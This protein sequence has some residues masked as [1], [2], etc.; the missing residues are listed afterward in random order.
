MEPEKQKPVL[1]DEQKDA[2]YC[3]DNAVI[4]AG[5]GSGKTLV[6]ASRFAWLVTQK[7]YR[8][9]EILT[10]TFT[11]KAAAQMYR[12]IYLQLAE[13]ARDDSGEKGAL[14]KQ[15]LDEFTQARIQ[16]LDSYCAAIV[17]QAAN[18]YGIKPDF[19]INEDRCRQLATDI[20]LPFL[21]SR[22][23]HH[24]IVRFYPHKSPLSIAKDIFAQALINYSH[25]DSP[26]RFREGMKDQS[27][28]ICREWKRQSE[29]ICAKLHEL[30]DVYCG[31]ENFHKDLAPLL[32]PFTAGSITFPTE[33]LADWFNKLVAIPHDSAIEWA[34]SHPQYRK[35]VNAFT[36]FSSICGL[37]LRKGSP[38]NNPAKDIIK[39][40]QALYREFSSVAVFCLQAGLIH[41]VLALLSELQQNYLDRKRS[42]GVLTYNDVAHLAKTILREQPDIRRS[43]KESFK[44]IMIDEFQDNNELQKDLLFLLAEKP[45][46]VNDS[47]PSAQD[48]T[49]GKLFFVGDEKQSIYRFRGAD[50]SVFRSLQKELG[51]RELPLK[52]NYRSA[53]ALIGAFNAIFG[54]SAFDPEGKTALA[55]NPAVFAPATDTTS[56]PPYEASFTPLRAD[57]KNMGKLT[58]CILDKQ[59]SGENEFDEENLL[60]VENEARFVAERI[61]ALL[62]EKDETGSL[63][64]QPGDIAILFRSRT[65]Q[66]IFEK[67]LML[68]NIPY[69]SE[70]LN[71][72]FFGGPVNDMMSVLRLAVYPKDKAAYAQIL[73]SPFAGLSLPGLMLCLSLDQAADGEPSADNVPFGDEPLALLGEEDRAKYR[74]GQRIYQKISESVC[75]QS[76]CSLISELWY[77]E[78]YR[79]ETEWNPKTAAYHEMY[80]YL[81]H[82]A[83][84]ADEENQTLASFVDEIQSLDNASE[85][86]SDIEIPLE[87]PSAV[88]LITI[89]KSKGLEFP[90][91]FLCCC[92]KPGMHD[93]SDDIFDTGASGITVT[94]PLPPQCR[95]YRDIRRSYF[96]ECSIAVEKAK[97]TAE[98]RRLL[99]VGMTRAE[100][101]LYLSGCLGISKE[102]DRSGDS[103]LPDDLSSDFSRQVKQFIESKMEKAEGRNA[104]SG[105]TILE[106]NTFFG[107][108]LPAFGAHIE[109]DEAFF[110]IEKIP[111]YNEQYMRNAEQHGSL[112]ANDQKGLYSFFR[113]VE[114][115]YKS[116]NAIETPLIPRKYFTPTSL[117]KAAADG[118][119]PDTFTVNREFSGEDSADIFNK[120]DTLLDRYAKQYGDDGEKFNSGSFGTIA[121]ICAEAVLAGQTAVIPPKLAGFL[122]PADADAF[123]SA[124]NELAQRFARSPLGIIARKAEKR[125]SEFTFRSLLSVDENEIFINGTIDLVFED[126][127][128]VYV[129]DFKTD[130]IEFPEEHIPQ[131]AC[132][133]RA[134]TDLFA[135]PSN[136]KCTIWLYY[137]RSG[138]AIDVTRQARDFKL[139]KRVGG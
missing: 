73:R 111:A 40:L 70:D 126:E 95:N 82:L 35:M 101:E 135:A 50:V 23:D 38:K 81:F 86:L 13:I 32:E 19:S 30:V 129:V 96:W 100:S 15:A 2:V 134:A 127:Q 27:V 53:P 33:G 119:L 128:T 25:I 45:E 51:G 77:G 5:A 21:I 20:A 94:P 14:A 110:S 78:G 57:K 130:G 103:P 31:N 123:L 89:H 87:R 116:I 69:A 60:P 91:V 90:V 79:Y 67:H 9:R 59:N 61:N 43:E 108:C 3:A 41:S 97:R 102:I 37:D 139:E 6:L 84:Q 10:L 47:V 7:K 117:L 107:L 17:R 54:G 28:I 66:H 11:R 136:K 36:F 104:I 39:E 109:Q 62:G 85:R 137:L 113:K 118:I 22:R 63:K 44:A 122:T 120:V 83:A 112:F 105:D 24:A 72:F 8:V 131:M 65:P 80:D 76:I 106:G 138:H 16:T 46:V 132:Y 52:T 49:P 99:Y 121:H 98:L 48:L 26:P 93:F 34:E 58:L 88:H 74:H 18:R 4:A 12:R 64:Y 133:Y 92:D 124:G 56:L 68:L 55:R 29:I 42:E 125:K 71:G 75:T 1:N 114:I 115:F